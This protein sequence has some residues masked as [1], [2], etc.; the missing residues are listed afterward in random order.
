[1]GNILSMGAYSGLG[2]LMNRYKKRSFSK[3]KTSSKKRKF[4]KGRKTRTMVKQQRLLQ[5]PKTASA[6]NSRIA[7]MPDQRLTR[8]EFKNDVITPFS[9]QFPSDKRLMYTGFQNT[10]GYLPHLKTVA[11]SII[12]DICGKNGL[13]FPTWNTGI[14]G[15]SSTQV[16]YS[17]SRKQIQ[18]LR[19]FY[20]GE[21]EGVIAE[22]A[23]PDVNILDE[24][25]GFAV[26]TLW[27]I[28][29]DLADQFYEYAQAAMYP[30]AVETL[31]YD[32]SLAA[33]QG[34]T[35]T[36][37]FRDDNFA[38]SSVTVRVRSDMNMTNETP[39]R[40][41][42]TTTDA[43]DTVP[44]SVRRY[45]FRNLAPEISDSVITG[46][47]NTLN[48]Q[49]VSH[50]ADSDRADGL[51]DLSPVYHATE[52]FFN[53]FKTLP[54]GKVVFKNLKSTSSFMIRPGQS[55]TQKSQF[56]FVGSLSKYL[57]STI[58]KKFFVSGTAAVINATTG[59]RTGGFTKDG[60]SNLLKAVRLPAGGESHVYAFQRI[61]RNFADGDVTPQDLKLAF[62]I[63]HMCEAY[64]QPFK[65]V[66]L[67][68]C[69][70]DTNA[71]DT[72]PGNILV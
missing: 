69:R 61:R 10:G 41:G 64:V 39:S 12:R 14:T 8:M 72:N 7:K 21:N 52:G 62:A 68:V 31:I 44:L 4:T 18:W 15:G 36:V 43:I 53:P 20:R 50:I 3:K 54:Q 29:N 42:A 38:N 25:A 13:K 59:V 2:G 51:L 49:N 11:G 71:W 32:Y 70:A 22:E 17:V 34:I 33:N 56:S 45:S 66:P 26:R 5:N 57:E 23:G 58:S 48:F 1:M 47:K 28:S 55:V 46:A 67:P 60:A 24:S 37:K 35:Q 65:A 40:S 30:F 16:L 63:R 6:V 19:I 27:E 9:A